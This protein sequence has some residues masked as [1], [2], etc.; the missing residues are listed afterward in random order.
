[1]ILADKMN[2]DEALNL[3]SDLDQA[4]KEADKRSIIWKKWNGEKRSASYRRSAGGGS[5]NPEEPIHSV[6]IAWCIAAD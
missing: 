2:S 5:K 6:Y 3:E 1:M 4:L